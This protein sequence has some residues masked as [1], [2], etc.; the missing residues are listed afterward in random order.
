[1]ASNGESIPQSSLRGDL[2]GGISAMLV[3]LPSSIAYGV[4]I[5]AVLGPAYLAHGAVAGVIGAVSLGI[6]AACL[7]SARQLISAPCAPAAAGETRCSTRR[8]SAST[9]SPSSVK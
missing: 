4:T 7:G 6:V 2:W 8:Y 9:R 5:V 1:M 3:A